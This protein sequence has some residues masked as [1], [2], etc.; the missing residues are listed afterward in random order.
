MQP[1]L[2]AADAGAVFV[3][4]RCGRFERAVQGQHGGRSWPNLA[5]ASARRVLT[6]LPLFLH[7]VAN[8]LGGHLDVMQFA[9]V[10]RDPIGR[11]PLVKDPLEHVCFHVIRVGGVGWHVRVDEHELVLALLAF[12][13]D[14]LVPEDPLDCWRAEVL[15]VVE[16]MPAANNPIATAR[17]TFSRA[18]VR[19]RDHLV[20]GV[21]DRRLCL[22]LHKCELGPMHLF[23]SIVRHFNARS[24]SNKRWNGSPATKILNSRP[25]Y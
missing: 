6:F 23:L 1:G 24:E 13:R 18:L 17:D 9:K 11:V 15:H 25:C 4:F 7:P 14:F 20:L 16:L 10:C 8:C 5:F 12:P 19:I 3:F 2:P 21:R 22:H